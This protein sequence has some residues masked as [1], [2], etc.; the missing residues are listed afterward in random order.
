MVR[1]LI[2]MARFPRKKVHL[3]L[4]PVL[5]NGSSIK[6]GLAVSMGE[7]AKHVFFQGFQIGFNILLCGRC[8]MS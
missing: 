5:R 2:N 4:M 1:K 3:W 8:G 7:A 6:V